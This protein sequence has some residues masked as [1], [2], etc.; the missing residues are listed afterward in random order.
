[1]ASPTQRGSQ[2]MDSDTAA[3]MTS[4]PSPS[5]TSEDTDLLLKGVEHCS[6]ASICPPDHLEE[7]HGL[8]T[9]LSRPLLQKASSQ[10]SVVFLDWE[11]GLRESEHTPSQGNHF[12]RSRTG[13]PRGCSSVLGRS[14]SLGSVVASGSSP[15]KTDKSSGDVVEDLIG[16]EL[17]FTPKVN[18]LTDA[19]GFKPSVKGDAHNNRPLQAEHDLRSSGS[20]RPAALLDE[21]ESSPPSAESLPTVSPSTNLRKLL[22]AQIESAALLLSSSPAGSQTQSL[23]TH[24]SSSDST[25]GSE[26]CSPGH[27]QSGQSGETL[28]AG[29]DP[30]DTEQLLQNMLAQR[31]QD[32]TR[33]QEE[34]KT[35]EG[36]GRSWE[37]EADKLAFNPAAPSVLQRQITDLKSHIN[38][39]QEANEN[40]VHE[41]AR[42]DEEI[43]QLKSEMAKL[44]LQYED[45]LHDALHRPASSPDKIIKSQNGVLPTRRSEGAPLHSGCHGTSVDSS[46]EISQLRSEARKLRE[47]NHRLHEENHWLKE[48][49]WDMRRQH[50]QLLRTILGGKTT[51]RDKARWKLGPNLELGGGL[52]T[53]TTQLAHSTRLSS[54]NRRTRKGMPSSECGTGEGHPH[55]WRERERWHSGDS[56]S[57]ESLDSESTDFLLAGFNKSPPA[58][59]QVAFTGTVDDSDELSD[60]DGPALRQS[61]TQLRSTAISKAGP[62]TAVSDRA[63]LGSQNKSRAQRGAV[64][65]P[66]RPFAPRSVADL[67]VGHLVKFSRPGGKISQGTVKYM[68]NLP[69]RQDIY[70]GVELE[71]SEVGRHNGT[72]EGIR[73]F[74]CKPNKGVFVSFSKVIMGWE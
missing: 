60:N 51:P 7:P 30:Q 44:R 13:T 74:L 43:S 26:V 27:S 47:A 29:H 22:S 64:V 70:L 55:S 69:G 61:K 11:G 33:A 6:E 25:A 36:Q 65:L 56:S 17:F 16:D 28:S 57:P 54:P 59:K 3:E 4:V 63:T 72:F 67:R 9:W 34:K 62:G 15:A 1:M 58:S 66:R 18:L 53:L 45:R 39:L 50:E 52:G 23:S 32:I 38:D 21:R 48:E 68:G 5:T 12:L 10:D 41:L 8:D 35:L 46:G 49:L 42:A 31:Q 73:Y 71:G 24:S 19:P 2:R 14:Q 20:S 37:R 40:S